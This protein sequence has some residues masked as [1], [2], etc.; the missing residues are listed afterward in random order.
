MI[1]ESRVKKTLLNMRV[2][3][4][5]AFVAVVIS[6]FTRKVFL[7][8]LGP[9]FMG[10]TT[11]V[12]GLLGF[13]NLAELGVGASI[14]YFLYK[15]IYD[16]D[17]DCINETI[18]I[19]GYLYRLIGGFILAAG[20]VFSLFLPLVF[21]ATS[22]AWGIIYLVFYGQLFCSLL[23]YFVNYKANTIFAADQRQYL[24]NGYFQLTQFSSMILQAVL[25]YYTRSFTLYVLVL[26][27]FAIINSVILNWKFGQVYPWVEADVQRGKVALRQ[28]PEIL[29]YVRRVFIHQIGRFV[30]SSAMPVIIYGYASLSVVTFY[31]NYT[32]LNN[33]LSG[34]IWGALSGTEASVGNLIAEGDRQKIFDCYRELFSIKFYVM[35]FLSLCLVSLSSDFIAVWLGAGYVLPALLVGLICADFFLNLVRN[36]TDQ[37]I[38]GYGLKAD[39]WVPICRVLSLG[40]IVLV[41]KHWG[42]TG[43]LVVPIVVQLTLTHIWKPYYL[44]RSGLQLP[45]RKYWLLV[46]ANL[47]PF[48]VAYMVSVLVVRQLGLWDSIVTSWSDF[49][50]KA[51]CFALPLLLVSLPLSWMMSDGMRLFFR[52]V[53]RRR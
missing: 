30:N 33:R 11:T 32:L 4:I 19:M 25:A 16:D 22:F 2:N 38:N 41:G 20:V 5:T 39:V 50:L 21:R 17:R 8:T 31:S 15:P 48:A 51:L 13:L 34:F 49:V 10:L 6:F 7:D 35:T 44:F 36:T 14:A 3:M 53:A 24:V 46:I 12:N 9:E 26:V 45:F 1:R 18:S 27:A 47:L 43:I 52:R 40:I 23:G 28:R 29:R 42:L 37:F